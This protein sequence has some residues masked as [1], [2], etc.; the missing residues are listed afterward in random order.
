MSNTKSRR[1]RKEVIDHVD[2]GLFEAPPASHLSRLLCNKSFNSSSNRWFYLADSWDSESRMVATNHPS[3]SNCN[4]IKP[5]NSNDH[6]DKYNLIARKNWQF[7]RTIRLFNLSLQ[8]RWKRNPLFIF[9]II[10]S[11]SV[12]ISVKFRALLRHEGSRYRTFP[13]SVLSLP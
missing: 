13:Y 3:S 7:N 2:L 4:N 1:I 10:L 5:T 9:F 12:C 11:Q 6:V 8:D